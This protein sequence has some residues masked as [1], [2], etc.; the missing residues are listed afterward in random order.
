MWFIIW[1]ITHELDPWHNTQG[2]MTPWLQTTITRCFRIKQPGD[3]ATA[4]RYLAVR[5]GRGLQ[6]TAQRG[7]LFKQ[8]TLDETGIVVVHGTID[9]PEPRC[10]RQSDEHQ[11]QHVPRAG[12]FDEQQDGQRPYD[13]TLFVMRHLAA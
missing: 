7:T 12:K 9:K 10:Y 6:N 5:C 2:G 1:A 11:A 8:L 4:L 3:V 13:L